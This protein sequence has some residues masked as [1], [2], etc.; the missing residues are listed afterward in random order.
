[1]VSQV[2]QVFSMTSPEKD[3][4][5]MLQIFLLAPQMFDL[6]WQNFWV[7]ENGPHSYLFL[8][9]Q[10]STCTYVFFKKSRLLSLQQPPPGNL[11]WVWLSCELIPFIHIFAS[12]LS[13]HS[14]SERWWSYVVQRLSPLS[15]KKISCLMQNQLYPVFDRI[16]WV[17]YISAISVHVFKKI[18][19]F[20]KFIWYS[21]QRGQAATF[22]NTLSCLPSAFQSQDQSTPFIYFLNHWGSRELSQLLIN[23]FNRAE[24]WTSSHLFFLLFLWDSKTVQIMCVL[25]SVRYVWL[26]VKGRES[27]SA[28]KGYLHFYI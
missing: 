19:S 10:S 18:F 11:H 1:M 12:G 20:I 16:W 22:P 7:K 4:A 3:S 9:K 13:W 27:L 21:Y 14:L 2:F 15:S 8:V 28:G 25:V 5:K 24:K 23:Y 17:I 6:H 26:T